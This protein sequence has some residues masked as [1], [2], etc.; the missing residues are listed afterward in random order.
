MNSFRCLLVEKDDQGRSRRTVTTLPTE[1]LGEGNVLIRVR[2]SSLNYKDA[3]AAE[4]HPGVVRK[5]PH[6]PGIDAAGIIEADAS[7]QFRVG[8][9]VI[10]TSYGLGADQW[11]GWS[12]LI[13]VPAEWVVR[14]PEGLS[15]HEAMILGTAGFTAAQCVQGLLTNGLTP[16]AGEIVVTGATGG[17]GCLAVMILAQ[18]G[19]PVVA[20]TGKPQLEARLKAWGASRVIGRQEVVSDSPKPLLAGKWAGG[21]DTVGGQTLA[22]ILRETK[23]YGVVAACGLVGGTDLPLTVHLFILRGVILAGISSQSLPADRRQDFWRK[24][25]GPWKPRHLD[26]VATTIGLDG[27]DDAVQRILKGQIAG[28]TVVAL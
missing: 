13:R 5:L 23:Q 6:V 28:R 9:E 26:D 2:F 1:R 21:I 15:L 16:D 20:V 3:L 25:A 4:A 19:F 27:L 14:R 8:E 22:T 11:G 18:L 7:G 24:L 12:E 17:V 10:V